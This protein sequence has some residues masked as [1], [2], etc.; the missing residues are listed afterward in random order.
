MSVP[1][2][3]PSLRADLVLEGGGVKGVAFG[4]VLG[5]L[6]ERGYQFER[7]AGTSAGAITAALVAALQRAGEPIL[8]IRDIVDTLDL[9]RF[10]DS[11]RVGRRLGPLRPVGD[12]VSLLVRGG[13]NEGAYLED[14]LTGVLADLG[15]R[16]FGDLRR[17]DPGSA[18]AAEHEF[19]LV[20]V[21]S[22]L[23]RRRMTLL[24]WDFG[25]Y[26]LDPDEQSVARAVRASAAIPFYF[27]PVDYPSER[28]PVSLVDGGLLSNYPIT[29][30]D[31]PDPS[32]ARWPTIGVRLSAREDDRG[33][34]R[35]VR[36]ALDVG[37]AVV[38][39]A[40]HGIDARHIDDPE[41]IAKTIF[42]DVGQVRSTDFDLGPERRAD[43]SR[44][45]AD[46]ARKWLSDA[47]PL[48]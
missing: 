6:A 15:V 31:R 5:V 36:T 28:G 19:S 29:I 3:P 23:S 11:N 14:W 32:A 41:A 39:T 44:R 26:G 13:L 25:G 12:I 30:F 1:P 37:L 42:V 40:M 46:A 27:R 47:A 24:P 22:D 4:G 38:D 35:P 2:P 17:D 16:T 48:H 43:L 34:T 45:G 18:L 9:T 7:S 20:V 10:A 8:R 33:V 21:T